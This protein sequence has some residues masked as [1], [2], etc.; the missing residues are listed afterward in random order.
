MAAAWEINWGID[1]RRRKGN[2][3]LLSKIIEAVSCVATASPLL[4]DFYN[5]RV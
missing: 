4:F 1:E 3:K 5:R 2:R